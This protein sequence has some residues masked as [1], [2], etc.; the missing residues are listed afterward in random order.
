MS[1]GIVKLWEEER[2]IFKKVY[3]GDLTEPEFNVFM[4]M[5]QSFGADPR[6][7]EIFAIRFKGTLQIILARDFYRAVAMQNENFDY[8]QAWD[9]CRNDFFEVEDGIVHHK[10]KNFFDRGELLGAYAVGK[11]KNSSKEIYNIVKFS[12][13][14]KGQ[15]TWSQIPSTMIKKV[16]EAQLLK[17]MAN[18][19]L[20]GVYSEDEQKIIE[21]SSSEVEEI[22]EP[23][24]LE[25]AKEKFGNDIINPKDK[26]D[27]T[28]DYPVTAGP[29]KTKES[30]KN[31]FNHD[32][33][34]LEHKKVQIFEKLSQYISSDE[35]RDFLSLATDGKITS[36]SEINHENRNILNSILQE[37]NNQ[38]RK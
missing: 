13:Y 23:P 16:A 38:F 7:R 26:D 18:G 2:Q 20:N 9:I 32:D 29:M 6:K 19:R 14:N 33:E 34:E 3:A 37:I 5:G 36:F 22:E 8:C 28:I 30:Q 10:I 1:T 12:E 11:L 17:L 31:L 25:S 27:D 35:I 24:I 4:M 15:A 21:I